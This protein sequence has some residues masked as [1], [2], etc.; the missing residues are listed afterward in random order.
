ML[1]MQEVINFWAKKLRVDQDEKTVKK[2]MKLREAKKKERQSKYG[3]KLGGK[4]VK[5]QREKKRD[6][7]RAYY[8]ED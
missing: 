3:N 1:S 2:R 5:I 4:A 7:K 8:G 6:L